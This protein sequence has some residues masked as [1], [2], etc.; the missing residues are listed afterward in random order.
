MRTTLLLLAAGCCL[1]MLL[2]NCN[3]VGLPDFAFQPLEFP[4]SNTGDV[5]RIA[6]YGIPNWSGSEP[7]NGIDLR[8]DGNLTSA[9][10]ISPT[11]GV[12][13]S[14]FTHENQY[15]DPPGQLLV[16]I[17]IRVNGEWTVSLV[18]EPSTVDPAIRTAQLAAI[19]VSEGQEVGVGTPVADLIV[20]TL[21]YPHMHYMMERSGENVCAYAHSSDAAKAVFVRLSGLPGSYLP[22]G[23]ICYGQP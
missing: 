16:T 21:G 13:T 2:A 14:I 15:S 3:G 11:A 7:H 22:D 1:A 9:R 6:G 17:A 23:N 20:G 19:L 5:V 4:F 10:I 12:V 8:V 18:L